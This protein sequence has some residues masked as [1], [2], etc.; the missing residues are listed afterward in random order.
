MSFS[1]SPVLF[2]INMK[3]MNRK[4]R[5]TSHSSIT[6]NRNLKLDTL[7]FAADQVILVD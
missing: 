2:I 6:I 3:D 1:L 4:W 7:L 5:L